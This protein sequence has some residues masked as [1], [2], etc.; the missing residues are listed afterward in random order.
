METDAPI[1]TDVVDFLRA[2]AKA[3]KLMRF[4][5][6]TNPMGDR[7]ARE[8]WECFQ[9]LKLSDSFTLGVSAHWFYLNDSPVDTHYPGISQLARQ[10]YLLHVES[11][12][13]DPQLTEAELV[14]FGR[15]LAR[16]PRNEAER[17]GMSRI[18]EDGDVTHVT[19]I[20]SQLPQIMEADQN[21]ERMLVQ[22]IGRRE[23]GL[24]QRLVQ[25]SQEPVRSQ[26]AR[27]RTKPG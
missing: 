3:V 8:C 23:Q 16:D 7:A 14:R 11:L 20:A 24:Q 12:T 1:Q 9:N 19:V 22:V 17:I 27:T 15:V 21:V 18:L 5:P 6:R 25:T 10:L 13:F 2:L 26:P 4:Y